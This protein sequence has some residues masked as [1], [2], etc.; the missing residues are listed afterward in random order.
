MH[1]I[2]TARSRLLWVSHIPVYS[3]TIIYV[4]RHMDVLVLASTNAF[5]FT[6]CTRVKWAIKVV[7]IADIYKHTYIHTYIECKTTL[8]YVCMYVHMHACV[9]AFCR[10]LTV[11]PHKYSLTHSHTVQ[12]FIR[13]SIFLGAVNF[14]Y[15]FKCLKL[16]IN[17]FTTSHQ[18]V[19]VVC[20]MRPAQRTQTDNWL[21]FD[22][23]YGC[24]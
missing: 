5:Y 8:L 16:Y 2:R 24:A 20:E 3:F 11:S 12:Q 7:K 19:K 23:W 17:S 1:F 18:P 6:I 13:G 14:C 21:Y 9:W 22:R 15:I 4:P 10:H